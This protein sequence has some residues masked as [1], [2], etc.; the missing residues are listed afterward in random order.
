MFFKKQSPKR[1]LVLLG[2]PDK[3]TYCG[4]LATAYEEGA[5]EGGHQVKRV[6]VGELSFDPL[7][8]K[9]YKVIQEL[10]PDVKKLQEDMR[11]AE[12]VVVIY[13][14]WWSTMP[15]VLKGLFD[16][17]WL[18]GFAFKFH[19]DKPYSWDKLLAGR[20]ARVV[21][22]M[23]ANPFLE[24][25]AIGDYTNEIRRGILGFAGFSPV[26]L[27]S[28]GPAERVSDKQKELWRAE[29]HR[30]GIKAK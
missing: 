10:E 30:L 9:G 20:T 17:M 22:T 12:H 28:F 4:S 8:H 23:N 21:L 27:T 25:L 18:P 24:R 29:V 7:L 6:N 1:I 5:R 26:A 19:K 11:W 3:E 15:A 16:R 13:P 2:H 14:N